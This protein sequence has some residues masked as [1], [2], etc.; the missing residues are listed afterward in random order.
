MVD[1]TN[2]REKEL[3]VDQVSAK[4]P[5]VPYLIV[6]KIDIKRR[7]VIYTERALKAVDPKVHLVQQ[8]NL[9]TDEVLPAPLGFLLRDGSSVCETHQE[10]FPFHREPYVVD[11]IEG[12]FYITDEGKVLEEIFP[13]E[14]P[15][16]YGKVTSNGTPMEQVAQ[17]RSQRFEVHPNLVCH[18]WD[19]PKDGCKYCNLFSI[20]HNDEGNGYSD[21]FWQD[22]TET[23]AE[24]F[25]QKGRYC[26]VHMTAGSLLTGVEPFE[27]ELDIYIK[28]IQAVEKALKEPWIPMQI[29]ASAF[30]ER[31]LKRLKDETGITSFDTDLEVLNPDIYEWVCPGKHKLIGHQEWINRIYKAVEVFGHGRVNTGIV[32]GVE[33][34]GEKGFTNED[35]AFEDTMKRA[36]ELTKNG[37]ALTINVWTPC[38]GSILFREN[39]PSLDYYV[40]VAKGFSEL[41]KKYRLSIIPDDYRRCGNHINLDLDRLIEFDD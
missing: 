1:I 21:S 38:K 15:D 10:V 34:T 22:I 8:V 13:W 12:R 39:N 32:V 30:N 29:V 36:E 20:H 33:F 9:N 18:F 37:S 14:R 23:A 5:D 7:G 16:F 17:V 28:S 6:L 27:D 25:K 4:Y 35:E 41:H 19:N 31:Q 40:R 24:A 3:N 11:Y 26:N 2:W